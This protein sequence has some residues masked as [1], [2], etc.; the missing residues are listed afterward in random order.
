MLYFL[1]FVIKHN[2]TLVEYA[3]ATY[4]VGA[5]IIFFACSNGVYECRNSV[6]K[7]GLLP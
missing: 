5:C 4:F 2:M 1:T 3:V 6:L 7:Y